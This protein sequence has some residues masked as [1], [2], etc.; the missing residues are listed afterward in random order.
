MMHQVP[1]TRLTAPAVA[2]QLERPVRPAAGAQRTGRTR[3]GV[4]QERLKLCARCAGSADRCRATGLSLRSSLRWWRAKERQGRSGAL[5]GEDQ[6]CLTSEGTSG[7]GEPRAASRDEDNQHCSSAACVQAKCNTRWM[8]RRLI[9]NR[10][11]GHQVRG[12]HACCAAYRKRELRQGQALRAA[13][14][15]P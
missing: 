10:R 6:R 15:R 14:G 1:R 5:N 11:S 2:G 7:N 12:L 3:D 9:A 8:I 4:V 13:F